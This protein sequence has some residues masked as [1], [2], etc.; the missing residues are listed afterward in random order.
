MPKY[1]LECSFDNGRSWTA[2]NNYRNLSK[3]KADFLVKLGVFF[4]ET[5]K[6]MATHPMRVVEEND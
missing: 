1:R 3:E 4:N 6:Q 2:L 5:H